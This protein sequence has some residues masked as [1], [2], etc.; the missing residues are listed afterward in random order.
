MLYG[1]YLAS[2]DDC[3]LGTSPLTNR[4]WV[5][6]FPTATPSLGAT[7]SVLSV[8]VAMSNAMINTAKRSTH[9]FI[10]F[11]FGVPVKIYL[12]YLNAFIGEQLCQGIYIFPNHK[13]PWS[14]TK[15]CWTYIGTNLGQPQLPLPIICINGNEFCISGK[16]ENQFILRYIL[17]WKAK[18]N[19][20]FYERPPKS[21]IINIL[22]PIIRKVVPLA[23][24]FKKR[25]CNN[26]IFD[27]LTLKVYVGSCNSRWWD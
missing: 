19:I 2:L 11:A 26:F 27:Y 9:F 12:N 14:W 13:W 22:L 6:F 15:Q 7:C 10:Q 21:L 8:K 20:L 23:H 18:N 1:G 16:R 25:I 5:S 3:F 17:F 24:L 4:L